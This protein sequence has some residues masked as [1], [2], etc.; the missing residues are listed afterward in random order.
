MEE[1][2]IFMYAKGM[3]TGDIWMEKREGIGYPI[4]LCEW[5]KQIFTNI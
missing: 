5:T 4:R 3:T 2:I 1:K